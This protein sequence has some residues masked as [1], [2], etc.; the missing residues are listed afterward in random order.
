MRDQYGAKV[1]TDLV[2]LD[3]CPKFLNNMFGTN[4]NTLEHCDWFEPRERK[5]I[6]LVSASEV[7]ESTGISLDTSVEDVGVDLSEGIDTINSYLKRWTEEDG[8]YHA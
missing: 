8:F 7:L 6:I 1:P 5:N 3:L 4:R 2:V